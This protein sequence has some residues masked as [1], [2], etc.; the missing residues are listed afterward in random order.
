MNLEDIKSNK[1][2]L[3]I[4]WIFI[5]AILIIVIVF[6]FIWNDRWT[7]DGREEECIWK[8]ISSVEFDITSQE[9]FETEISACQKPSFTSIDECKK[10]NWIK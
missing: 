4:I 7:Y 9:C 10:L 2:I 5:F 8:N 6:Y 1:N 3:T